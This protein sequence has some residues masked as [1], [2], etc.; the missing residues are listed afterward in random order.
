MNTI[1]IDFDGVLI[2]HA[3]S[4]NFD[5]CLKYGEPMKNSVEI[6]N[7]LSDFYNLVVMT[8]REDNE[9]MRIKQ[10]LDDKGFP[11]MKVTN[12][13]INATLYIDDRCLRF[14]NWNDISKYLR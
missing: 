12:R 3:H 14:T 1:A 5:D 13:K 11:D 2:S 6:L 9:L 10:W 8:A 4:L 7:Y